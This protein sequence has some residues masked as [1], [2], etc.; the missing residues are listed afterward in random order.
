MRIYQLKDFAIWATKEKIGHS[1]LSKAVDELERGLID[2]ILLAGLY[3]KRI[4]RQGQG[5]RDGYR[6]ILAYRQGDMVI[7]LYGFAKNE[8][9]NI[10]QKD[11]EALKKLTEQY[12]TMSNTQLLQAI[13]INELVE[14]TK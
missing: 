3:K 7:F 4:A 13:N 6:T 12:L 14:V 1:A 10:S 11:K 2:A 8:K 5:K 9:A